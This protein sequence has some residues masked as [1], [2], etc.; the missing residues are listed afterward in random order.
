MRG[1]HFS[2]EFWLA[3]V[4]GK[5]RL[6]PARSE[7]PESWSKGIN[8]KF[9]FRCDCGRITLA[10]MNNVTSGTVASCGKCSWKSKEFWLSQR[11]GS[12]RL[13]PSQ[14]L[15]EE[16][17]ASSNKKFVFLC[18]CG[19][20][21]VLSMAHVS[22]YQSCGKCT[23]LS[24][25]VW[26]ARKFG[27]L[28]LDP[29]QPLPAFLAPHSNRLL[30]FNCDCG[31][32]VSTHMDYVTT[33]VS[34]DGAYTCGKCSY[35]SKGFW[36]KQKWN[37]LR[38]DPAQVLPEEWARYSGNKFRFIC[39]C[40]QLTDIRMADVEETLS[41]GCLKPGTSEYSPAR[42]VF[43][44][45]KTLAP[46]ALFS[47]WFA[48]GKRKLEY[49][50][51]VPSKNLAI[52][53][54]GLHWHTE[55]MAGRK[56]FDKYLVSQALGHRLVQ[57]YQDEWEEKR[58][59]LKS[60][61]SEILT[62]GRKTRIRPEFTL[63]YATSSAVRT[64]LDQHH[65]LGAASGCLTVV[66]RHKGD[67]VGAWVF[68]KRETGTVLWH[69]ACWDH[70]FKSWNPHEKAL[71]LAAPELVNMGF[72]R[73]VTFSDNRFHTGKLYETLG[74]TFE[75]D[76]PSD[77]SYTDGYKHRKGK[78]SFRVKAGENEVKLA[79]EKGWHRVWDS[80]KRRYSLVL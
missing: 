80:G 71:K 67:I 64:F 15:P 7:L 75:S 61:L 24:I 72:D 5:L 68:M 70:R 45:V 77:Y 69:R 79:E 18:G 51:F 25:D 17:G 39:D 1:E 19:K 20:T 30:R 59:I 42:E 34:Q 10:T 16:F 4:W 73:I 28:V 49:D 29:S 14:K 60:Q 38:L 6:E 36:S 11:W 40:G 27:S 74:F 22:N 55:I 52:E 57:I 63:E 3:Q 65:Y 62:S 9:V 31:R 35:R 37:R 78:L 12:L 21:T 26:L 23:E 54:H 47:H 48:V 8:L 53:Y 66:A 32:A 76:L 41:C 33:G 46:D 50:I 56:D 13:D 43:D 2:R 44:F 58:D